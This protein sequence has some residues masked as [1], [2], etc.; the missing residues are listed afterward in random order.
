[1]AADNFT[2][3]PM[4]R[5]EL[6]LALDWAAAEGWNPGLFDAESFYQADPHG[7]FLGELAG[8]PI[9]CISAVAYDA[10]FGFLGLYIVKPAFR[11]QGFGQQMWKVALDYL[12]TERVIGLDSVLAQ[13]E[14]YEKSGFQFAYRHLRHEG[15]GGESLPDGAINLKTV[16][17]EMLLAYD[18]QRFPAKREP[19]LR[20]WLTQPDSV[21][22]GFLTQ[23][24]LTGYGVIRP[25]RT[26]FK[27]GP[28]FADSEEIARKLLQAL[29][30]QAP[31][32]PVFFDT[33]EANPAA[34]TLARSW[35]M[36]PI[37]ETIRM[38]AHGQPD[39]PL[40]F[41]FGVTT[42]ELG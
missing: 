10:H 32:A 22:W 35:G 21:G 1:M 2:V 36:K 30:A 42:L 37:F 26:G 8:K 19:F 12:G 34:L 18:R 25:C 39:I 28:L 15:I 4:M 3:R 17:F 27:I 9:A 23:E 5:D 6:A 31:N 14:N 40:E 16:P 7:F 20:A 11:G 13:Q 29:L 33:P 38:Y 41:V 24:R